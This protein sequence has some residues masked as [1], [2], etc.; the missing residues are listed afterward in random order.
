V[1]GVEYTA[2]WIEQNFDWSLVHY[3][4]LPGFAI[5]TPPPGTLSI[6]DY[7]IALWKA[8]IQPG[9]SCMTPH[10][11]AVG[12]CNAMYKAAGASRPPEIWYDVAASTAKDGM[13]PGYK[14]VNGALALDGTRHLSGAWCECWRG[15]IKPSTTQYC[16]VTKTESYAACVRTQ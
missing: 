14:L 6:K 16:K 1:S 7:A 8:N 9:R 11:E 15:A 10:P 12:A 5:S 3:Y 4:K 2:W 13:R